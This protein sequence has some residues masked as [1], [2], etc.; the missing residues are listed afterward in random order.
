[1]RTLGRR[2]P[3]SLSLALWFLLAFLCT[4]AAFE[5]YAL[6]EFRAVLMS[7]LD[8][9][10]LAEAERT[11]EDL[12]IGS[13]DP[14][15]PSGE[16]TRK[17]TAD[18]GFSFRLVDERGNVF[19]VRDDFP[20]IGA[21][22]R[23]QEGIATYRTGMQSFRIATSLVPGGGTGVRYFLQAAHSFATIDEA[24]S[25]WISRF[26]LVLPVGLVAAIALS[27]FLAH[28]ALRPMA[29]LTSL[30]E[31]VQGKKF[32]GRMNY[33][34]PMDE[35]GRLAQ[36]FDAM[37]EGIQGSFE[38]ERRFSADASHEL[39]TPLTALKGNLDVTLSQPRSAQE[40][41]QSLAVM[42]EQ[43]DRLIRLSADLLIFARAGSH[44]FDGA[45]ERI[46]LSLL[47][48]SC[49]EQFRESVLSKG[50]RMTLEIQEEVAVVGLPDHLMRLFLNLFDNAVK[51]ADVGGSVTLR[52][53]SLG[54]RAVVE[55]RNSGAGLNEADVSKVFDPFF[56][57]AQ[58][59]SRSSGG[60][61][62]GLAIAREIAVAHGGDISLASSQGS[63]TKVSVFLP[64]A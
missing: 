62:L 18:G 24:L 40:Y 16:Q 39:R 29:R 54:Q 51:Y 56:R 8:A 37:L 57:G 47:L 13:A 17:G 41:R 45:R 55:L 63:G 43:V 5:A 20:D 44:A 58:D 23:P 3:F 9:S 31:S 2:L 27:F 34:G 53:R 21:S 19:G 38:R 11:A 30:A 60:A 12:D 22:T 61:G 48:E 1:M 14:L 10:L 52:A 15:A 7:Q 28:G 33:S 46:D 4:V 25:N 35:I 50:L 6:G 42:A 26:L 32:T 59:R 49:A 36:S 64:L